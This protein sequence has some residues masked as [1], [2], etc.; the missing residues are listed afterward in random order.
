MYPLILHKNLKEEKWFSYPQ[1]QQVIMIANELNR[2]KNFILTEDFREVNGCYERAFELVDITSADPRWK[3][4]QLKELR[5][6]RE[7]LAQQYTSE[8][9]D[10]NL[11]HQL[12]LGLLRIS[13][14]AYRLL[15]PAEK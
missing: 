3:G 11:N 15:Y 14:E 5:R 2:A 6:F 4:N 12:Y 1:S 13:P 8:I 10:Q 9:K 7:I